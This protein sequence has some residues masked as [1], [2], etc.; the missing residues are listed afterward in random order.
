MNAKV[1]DL[2]GMLFGTLTVIEQGT[3]SRHN[4]IKW[5]CQCT[6]GKRYEVLGHSLVTGNTTKCDEHPRNEWVV[7]GDCVLIDVSTPSHKNKWTKI[8]VDDF[9]KVLKRTPR[10]R[11]LFHDSAPGK[12]WG[13][14]VVDSNRKTRLHRLVCGV[15]G[16]SLIP[17]HLNGDT[18]DNRKLNLRL[19]TRS[20]NNMNMRRSSNN[21]S[22]CTGVIEKDGRWY[23]SIQK[24]GELISLGHH[25]S[26]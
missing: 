24:E 15:K 22:G 8:D 5:V 2:K 11:W 12:T 6:C 9:E 26:F 14:Y 17:D 23:A 3:R 18:L 19:V 16:N 10:T 25:D 21:T 1:K 20:Q 7:K 13:K 4:Q